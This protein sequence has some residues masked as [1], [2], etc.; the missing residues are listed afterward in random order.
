MDCCGI[1]VSQTGIGCR[2]V[3]LTHAGFG[4]SPVLAGKGGNRLFVVHLPAG[5]AIDFLYFPFSEEYVLGTRIN[6]NSIR[7]PCRTMASVVVDMYLIYTSA[8]VQV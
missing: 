3:Y 7:V 5:C 8:L 2:S 6:C 4:R 1:I